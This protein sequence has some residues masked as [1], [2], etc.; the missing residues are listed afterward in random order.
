MMPKFIAYYTE[1]T[2]YE[3]E[4]ETL[5]LSLKALGLEHELRGIESLGTWQRNTQYKSRF[6]RDMLAA[7]PGH[8]LVYVDVDAL[9]IHPPKLFDPF[10]ADIA[11][12][13]FNGGELLGGTIY[14][15]NTPKTIEVVDRWIALCEE[16]PERI[17]AGRFNRYPR[18][19]EAWDQRLL[20]MAIQETTG[21]NFTHLPQSY[22]YIIDLTRAKHPEA[23][24]V[25]LHTRGSYR[26]N[27]KHE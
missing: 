12:T 9:V 18:G 7:H 23:E 26:I 6:I 22:C 11:A 27:P 19:C 13:I 8:P 20:H 2:R 4:A 14:L 17:P 16:F 21:L 5:R 10:E 3:A 24:P 1:N 25:I 15:G